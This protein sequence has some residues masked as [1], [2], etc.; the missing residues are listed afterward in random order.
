[1]ERRSA[2]WAQFKRYKD[3]LDALVCAWLGTCFVEG[4]VDAFGD[5]KAAIFCPRSS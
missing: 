2:V 1:V 5:E 4:T 3:A